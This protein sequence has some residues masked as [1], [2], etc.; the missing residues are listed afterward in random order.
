MAELERYTCYFSLDEVRT[1][2]EMATSAGVSGNQIARWAVQYL[3]GDS[4]PPLA[5]HTSDH[6]VDTPSTVR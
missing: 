1:L 2:K 5:I 3:R 4:I 6:P